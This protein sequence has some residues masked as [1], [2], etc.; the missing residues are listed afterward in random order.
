MIGVGHLHLTAVVLHLAAYNPLGS[1]WQ[2]AA[3]VVGVGAEE[4]QPQSA[5]IVAAAYLV[6]QP[7]VGLWIVTFYAN[8]DGGDAAR[9]RISDRW[10]KPSID[11]SGR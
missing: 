11:E 10:R 9:G 4:D 8:A 2:H 5:G 7:A 6:G 3:Q 1:L